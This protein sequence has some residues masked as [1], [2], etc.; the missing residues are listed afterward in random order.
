MLVCSYNILNVICDGYSQNITVR[1][2]LDLFTV[3]QV[4]DLMV[5]VWV[6]FEYIYS[7]WKLSSNIKTALIFASNYFRQFSKSISRLIIRSEIWIVINIF[8]DLIMLQSVLS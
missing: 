3:N 2:E 7:V 5:H 6:N 4:C 1:Q 8:N